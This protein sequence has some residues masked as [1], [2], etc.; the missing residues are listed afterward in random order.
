MCSRWSSSRCARTAQVRIWR[1]ISARWTGC[2][3]NT[4]ERRSRGKQKKKRRRQGKWLRKATLM[5]PIRVIRFRLSRRWY[6]H[7]LIRRLLL[8]KNIVRR[9]R[10]LRWCISSSRR[11]KMLGRLRASIT[12][13]FSYSQWTAALRTRATR[14]ACWIPQNL[15]EICPTKKTWKRIPAADKTASI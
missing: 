4:A 3:R 2:L 12:H 9:L 15:A 11:R 13:Q 6:N 1:S 5:R 8:S 14:K 7:L 10:R